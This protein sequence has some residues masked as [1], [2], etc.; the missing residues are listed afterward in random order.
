MG[1]RQ[2][3]AAIAA[4]GAAMVLSSIVTARF[5]VAE[6]PSAPPHHHDGPGPRPGVGFMMPGLWT[7][8]TLARIA[9]RLALSDEQRRALQRVLE[10]ARPRFEQLHRQ[11]RGDMELLERTRPD[12]GAFQGVVASATQ[13]ASQTAAQMV[14]EGS[15]LRSRIYGTLA[16]AQREQLA[17]LEAAQHRERRA[18]MQRLEHGDQTVAGMPEAPDAPH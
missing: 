1:L 8:P 11:M 13:S 2:S 4:I 5:A 9:D 6:D 18:R 10:E 15:Q 7:A 17:A 14:L 12:D 16:P 3:L